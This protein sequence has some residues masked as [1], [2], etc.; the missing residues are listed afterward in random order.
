LAKK[1][2]IAEGTVSRFEEW[3]IKPDFR[4]IRKLAE[5]LGVEPGEIEFWEEECDVQSS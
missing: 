2:R 3:Y 4:T 1:A 5:A